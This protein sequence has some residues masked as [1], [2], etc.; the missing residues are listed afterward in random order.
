[1]LGRR[2]FAATSLSAAAFAALAGVALGEDAK[3]DV[4]ARRDGGP[5]HKEEF[6][7]CAEACGRCQRECD[8]CSAHC[9]EH[10]V[11]GHKHHLAT[12][13]SCRD[14][15]DICS[16]AAE[17]VARRGVLSDIICSACADACARCANACEEHGRDDRVMKACAEE[18]RRCERACRDMIATTRRDRT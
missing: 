2:E 8:A 11:E 17:I 18:C 3:R 4:A 1:M 5:H 15:A 10:I 7:K 12:L 14:C 6:D 13:Q 9:T 16:A